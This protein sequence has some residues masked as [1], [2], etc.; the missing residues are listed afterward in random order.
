M[1]KISLKIEGMSCSACANR[2][3]RIVNKLDGVEKGVV[4]FA[5][6]T[7]SLEYHE[8][9]TKLDE[10][11]SAIEKAG[12]KVKK[13]IKDYTFKVEGM[14]CSACANRIEKVTKKLEGVQFASVNFATEK[15]T[16]KIDADLVSY[17]QIKSV[18]EEA[19]F[20][21]ISETDIKQVQEKKWGE[22]VK[23][24]VRFIISLMF[25]IPLLIVS[26]GHMVGMPLP[27]FID[28][29]MNPLN[30]AITQLI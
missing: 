11:K 20:Q 15:L 24:L 30:F 13:N 29:M 4:N 9:I 8:E 16:I 12:F 1:K 7:L 6:E 19:G 28:P 18:V 22:D 14:S 23:L 27:H 25:A 17:G 21:L 26:M 10:V 5:T 2:I 3:E